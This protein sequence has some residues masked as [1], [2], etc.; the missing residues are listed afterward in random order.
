MSLENDINQ[1]LKGKQV[2]VEVN[3]KSGSEGSCKTLLYWGTYKGIKKLGTKQMIELADGAH[4][5]RANINFG[6]GN[7]KTNRMESKKTYIS[8]NDIISIDV[9][10]KE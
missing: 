8:L 2:H 10:K 6:E 1:E 9:D 4:Y 5:N 3:L 7:D